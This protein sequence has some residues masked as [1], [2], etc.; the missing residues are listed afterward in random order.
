MSSSLIII[1]SWA[2][3]LLYWGISAFNVKKEAKEMSTW[4]WGSRGLLARAIIILALIAV[5]YSRGHVFN[6]F[7][8]LA[9]TNHGPIADLGAAFVVLGVALA[10]WARVHLGRNWSS[11]PSLKEGHELV[12]S[13]PYKV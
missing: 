2:I 8:A 12:T 6:A 5:A 13:G 9:K 7:G 1:I 4:Y 3:F 11:H 10:I